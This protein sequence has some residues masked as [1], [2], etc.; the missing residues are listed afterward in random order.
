MT[1]GPG[2]RV[3]GGARFP[4][5]IVGGIDGRLHRAELPA[6]AA[7]TVVL[8]LRGRYDISNLMRTG[9]RGAEQRA[10][11]IPTVPSANT[12]ATVVAIAERAAT[13]LG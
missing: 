8:T 1:P 2:R 7:Q 3:A 4:R 6:V 5:P 11:V 12:N 10:S 9:R 13:F